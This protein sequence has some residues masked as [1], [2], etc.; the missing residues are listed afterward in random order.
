MSFGAVFFGEN[1]E[2]TKIFIAQSFRN[3]I[4][5]IWKY[6]TTIWDELELGVWALNNGPLYSSD[7]KNK[8]LRSRE[9]NH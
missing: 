4:I 5:H 9:K 2:E 3:R 7:K 6:L 1:K 8:L